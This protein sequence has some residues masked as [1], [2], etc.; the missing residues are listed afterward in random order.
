ML[1]LGFGGAPRRSARPSGRSTSRPPSDSTA[2]TD[3]DGSGTAD[4]PRGLAVADA[5]YR[6]V[7]D[8]DGPRR[9]RADRRS[10]FTIVD[11]DGTAV[12]AFDEL[13]ERALHLIV[14]SPRHGRLPPPAPVDGRRAGHGGPSSCPRL[15]PGSY[16]VFADFQPTGADN[17]TLGHR[18]HRRPAR[19]ARR[20]CPH[21]R[22]VADRRRVH[23]HDGRHADASA[24]RELRFTVERARRGRAHRARTSAPP[25][26]WS[27]SAAAT[28][29]TCTSTRTRTRRPPAR[30][31]SRPSSRLPARTGCSSTSPTA[32]PCAPRRSP[33][34]SPRPATRSLTAHEEH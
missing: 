21:R 2:S 23:R 5:G 15:A 16:R 31:R 10:A 14:L 19:S 28:S 26:T 13:H 20:S 9:R 33:S 7:L 29:P 34:T 3:G 8:T 12:T 24:T 18:H 17:L 27:R 32:A 1:A 22:H 11:D 4:L 25:A 6:L 30:S